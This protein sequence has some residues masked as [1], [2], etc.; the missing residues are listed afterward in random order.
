MERIK[1]E[2]IK[3]REAKE[4][5]L[6]RQAEEV[7][8]AASAARQ[9]ARDGMS[10]TAHLLDSHPCLLLLES[11]A[12]T[13]LFYLTGNNRRGDLTGRDFADQMEKEEAYL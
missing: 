3:K 2:G 12:N 1:Q 6:R 7:E 10:L 5:E 11:R 13:D 8:G 9:A 4:A